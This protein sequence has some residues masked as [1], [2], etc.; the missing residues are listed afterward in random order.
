MITWR[1]AFIGRTTSAFPWLFPLAFETGLN[2][3]EW[4]ATQLAITSAKLRL[5]P[6]LSILITT[7]R[8]QSFRNH[9]LRPLLV[10]LL[11][12]S[13]IDDLFHEG[14][15]IA[16]VCLLL[17]VVF[18]C[19]LLYFGLLYLENA[20]CWLGLLNFE[21]MS[22]FNFLL[23]QQLFKMVLQCCLDSCCFFFEL[24]LRLLFQLTCL[25]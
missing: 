25:L 8:V 14:K 7:F 16:D 11:I 23:L 5:Q 2:A 1:L 17:V 13:S 20:F 10:R 4:V 12:Q 19:K 9:M 21:F 15:Q 22:Y 24:S 18:W 3:F 6:V